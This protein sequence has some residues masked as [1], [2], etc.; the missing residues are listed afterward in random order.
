MWKIEGFGLNGLLEQL[1]TR[2]GRKQA[3]IIV[4]RNNPEYFEEKIQRYAE[5]HLHGQAGRVAEEI[6]DYRRALQ[7]YRKAIWFH[8]AQKLYRRAIRDYERTGNFIHAAELAEEMEDAERAKAYKIF[9][10]LS[11]T[12]VSDEKV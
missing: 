12:G 4:A 8:R 6:G 3:T 2:E 11:R 10:D 9:A 7:F 5:G 1:C